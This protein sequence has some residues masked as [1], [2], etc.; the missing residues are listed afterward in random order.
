MSDLCP[1]CGKLNTDDWPIEVD[2]EIKDGGCQDCWEAQCDESWWEAV[3][4]YGRVI[5]F[6][7]EL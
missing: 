3:K 2:G 1:A 7:R 6:L 4:A 5:E